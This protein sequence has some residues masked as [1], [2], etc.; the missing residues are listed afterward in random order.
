MRCAVRQTNRS[1]GRPAFTKYVSN[2]SGA[3]LDRLS[4]FLQFGSAINP[5][6]KLLLLDYAFAHGMIRV[7]IITDALNAAS[8]AAIRKL[9]AT[10]E[11]T[12]RQHK[13]TWTGRMR[14][15]AQFSILKDVEWP[16]VRAKLQAR[17]ANRS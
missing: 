1:W 14:D 8:Q 11:G 7:E 5:A 2:I 15:T 13:R 17:L 3:R 9:G 16:E 6:S 4:T 12:L 10:F